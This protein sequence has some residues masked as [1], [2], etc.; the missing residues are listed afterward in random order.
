[1]KTLTFTLLLLFGLFLITCKKDNSANGNTLPGR[2][3]LTQ[4][5]ADIGTGKENYIPVPKDNKEYI[6]F[7]TDGTLDGSGFANGASY[8]VKDS[9]TIAITSKDNTIENY[10]YSIKN[11]TL[12]MSPAGPVIC[13]EGCGTRY[14]KLR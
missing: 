3:K 6:I 12:Q 11:G 5:Y 8:V 13:I 9:I 14:R 1:M 4:T 7:N 2:W 10:R